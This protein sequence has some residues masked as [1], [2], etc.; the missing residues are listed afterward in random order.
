MERKSISAEISP[1]TDVEGDRRR[2]KGSFTLHPPKA[3]R[4][5]AGRKLPFFCLQEVLLPCP[6]LG[7]VIS[8][9]GG[10]S[11]PIKVW[12]LQFMEKEGSERKQAERDL[13][14]QSQPSLSPV[15]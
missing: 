12:A 13:A 9:Q 14:L 2:L 1:G 5:G 10:Q 11:M 7:M 15:V 3:S 4:E 8:D 6:E